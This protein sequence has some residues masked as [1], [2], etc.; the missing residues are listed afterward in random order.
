MAVP[1]HPQMEPLAP[2]LGT[3]TGRGRGD[4]PTVDAF[5]YEESV[6]FSHVGKP[7]FMY[8]QRTRSPVDGR[9]LHAE[10]GFWRLPKPDW[11]EVVLA[12]QS[13]IVEIDEG[14]LRL[15]T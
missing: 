6:T 12:I 13:G 3:W 8:Q 14:T 11:I 9:P 15:G 10:F 1:I 7:S 4:Y 5:E 2:L